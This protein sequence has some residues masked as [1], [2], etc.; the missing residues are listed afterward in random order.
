VFLSGQF[1]NF[2]S[3]QAMGVVPSGE[4][5]RTSGTCE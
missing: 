5:A 4:A 3:R 1:F 2:D